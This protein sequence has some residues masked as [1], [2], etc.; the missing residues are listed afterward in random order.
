[1]SP[2]TRAVLFDLDG[3]LVDSYETWYEVV[4][5]AARHFDA[6]PVSR[7]RLA[8]VF[9]QGPEEDARTLY[10]GRTVDEIQTAYAEAMPAAVASLV[11]GPDA[12]AALDALGRRGIL[13]AVVTNTQHDVA[14]HILRAAGLLARLDA[15]VG[16]GG[17]LREKP[18]PDLV[19]R[20]LALL[21]VEA[22]EALFVG[23][24][25]YDEAAARAAS[26]PFLHF[27]LPTGGALRAA[28]AGRLV[29]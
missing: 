2:A 25:G 24:T 29:D 6:P 20:A 18:A 1:M 26:V 12:H 28:L 16:V 21:G 14:R 11:V 17:G 15:W 4:N 19:V 3:V 9:G 10:R 22:G 7:E 8:E 27:D 5:A 23:D 13:R